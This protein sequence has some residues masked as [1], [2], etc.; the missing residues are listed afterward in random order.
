MQRS[1]RHDVPF[2]DSCTAANDMPGQGWPLSVTTRMVARSTS[3]TLPEIVCA[4]AGSASPNSA[5]T[6]LLKI[7]DP[8]LQRMS[9]RPISL[10]K[11]LGGMISS[12]PSLHVRLYWI[13]AGTNLSATPFMQ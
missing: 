12:L 1:E 3:G 8:P 7:A 10:S 6:R 4:R 9:R 2:A 5:V 11:E 13:H